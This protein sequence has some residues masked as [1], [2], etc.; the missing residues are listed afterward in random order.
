MGKIGNN[1]QPIRELAV[2]SR[3]ATNSA[4]DREA[5][6]KEAQQLKAEIDRVAGQA[7]FNG[8]KLLDGSFQDQTF[9]VGANQG[10][11]IEVSGIVDASSAQLGSWTSVDTAGF[12]QT[13]AA[14]TATDPLLAAS[15]DI[16]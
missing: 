9:Q 13:T 1:L 3:N 11:T 6:N 12:T 2:Q 7:E 14:A 8:V 16:T 4:S 10:E 15:V 5:L